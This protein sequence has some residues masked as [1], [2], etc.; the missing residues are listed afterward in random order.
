MADGREPRRGEVWR[1]HPKASLGSTSFFRH[2]IERVFNS[3]T[4]QHSLFKIRKLGHYS[5]VLRPH[6]L[7]RPFVCAARAMP[8]LE[9]PTLVQ[10]PLRHHQR[11]ARD[12]LKERQS[13]SRRKSGQPSDLSAQPAGN[14]PKMLRLME[15]LEETTACQVPR[16][17]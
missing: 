3:T 7:C 15:G 9:E 12:E 14:A 6:I 8:S 1:R 5:F 2:A 4:T 17:T 11:P 10:P 13:C 16:G